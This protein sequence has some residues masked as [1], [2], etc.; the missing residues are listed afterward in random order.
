MAI[1]EAG[2]KHQAVLKHV[3]EARYTEFEVVIIQ[4]QPMTEIG[5]PGMHLIISHVIHN[6]AQV[7]YLIAQLHIDN[8]MKTILISKKTWHKIDDNS[9][10]ICL[11][12]VY[13][14]CP[15][16]SVRKVRIITV[17]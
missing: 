6:L 7:I 13:T 14:V 2:S 5:A 11:I 12:W 16:L 15:D 9:F 10:R 8:T 4:L 3:V 1:G 17:T